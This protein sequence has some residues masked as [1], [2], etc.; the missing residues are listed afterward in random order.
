MLSPN[1]PV[2]VR[3][4]LELRLTVIAAAL[5]AALTHASEKKR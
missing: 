1:P 2:N 4:M 3:D 5:I